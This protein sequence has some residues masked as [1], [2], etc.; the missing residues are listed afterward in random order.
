MNEYCSGILYYTITHKTHIQ[1]MQ[2][3]EEGKERERER[4]KTLTKT[5]YNNFLRGY[6]EKGTFV[7]C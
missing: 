5:I 7:H 4:I 3:G 6:E 1:T 2:E